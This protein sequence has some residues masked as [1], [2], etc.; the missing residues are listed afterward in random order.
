MVTAIVHIKADV[1][2]IPEVAQAIAD[3][4]GVSE[5]YSITGE[6]DLLAMVR[7]P[8]YEDISA[9]VPGRLNKVPGVRHTETHIAFRTYSRHDLEAAFSIGLDDAD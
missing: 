3:I 4:D 6:F 8:R 2:R 9:V 1:D 7:V 5:V